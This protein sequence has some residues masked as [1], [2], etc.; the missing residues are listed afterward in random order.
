[1]IRLFLIFLVLLTGCTK[2]TEEIISV[3]LKPAEIE[4]VELELPAVIETIEY[5]QV[6]TAFSSV[7][8]H[9]FDHLNVTFSNQ[10]KQERF[11]ISNWTDSGNTFSVSTYGLPFYAGQTYQLNLSVSSSVA[12]TVKVIFDDYTNVIFEKSY[13]INNQP[14]TIQLN[15]T[16][17]GNNISDGVMKL[18]FTKGNSVTSGE[19][20]IEE[21]SFQRIS[22]VDYNVKVN[23]VGYLPESQKDIQPD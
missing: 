8:S 2:E 15:Y 11:E 7:F 16:H 17:T 21:M 4:I 13:R 9:Q 3:A 19:I 20:V 5:D 18:V 23:Q 22:G 14:Q 12:D 6:N 10:L 1:M